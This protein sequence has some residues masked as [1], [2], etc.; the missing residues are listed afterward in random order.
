MITVTGKEDF[1]I[2]WQKSAGEPPAREISVKKIEVDLSMDALLDKFL[3]LSD[4]YLKQG[5]IKKG[6]HDEIFQ[7]VGSLK[8]VLARIDERKLMADQI[9]AIGKQKV[10]LITDQISHIN[11]QF[12]NLFRK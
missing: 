6:D 8:H 5:K 7:Q 2:A 1:E 12:T 9:T 4:K 11:S 10:S 3:L